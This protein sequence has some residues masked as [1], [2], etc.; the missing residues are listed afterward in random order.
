MAKGLSSRKEKKKPK[1]KKVDIRI[2]TIGAAKKS[3]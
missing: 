1:K 2:Q 3:K